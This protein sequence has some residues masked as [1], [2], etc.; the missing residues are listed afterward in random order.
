MNSTLR[1]YLAEIGRR[2]GRKSRRTLSPDEARR[3]V[4]VREARRAYRR[5]HAQ[6]FWSYPPD[7]VIGV[8]DVPWVAEQLMR[9]GGDEAWA[10]GARLCR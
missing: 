7:L 1:S 4:R 8:D 9:N 6:C 2:G 10:V 5:F 3:M